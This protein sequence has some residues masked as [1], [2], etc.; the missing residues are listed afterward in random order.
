MRLGRGFSGMQFRGSEAGVYD[1]GEGHF[2]G[3]GIYGRRVR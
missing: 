3:D 1:M 2:L